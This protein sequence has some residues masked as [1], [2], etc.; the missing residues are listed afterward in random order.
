MRKKYRVEFERTRC[1]GCECIY[2]NTTGYC[3]IRQKGVFPAFHSQS[4]MASVLWT[5]TT[6]WLNKKMDNNGF[7]W[8]F[9]YLLLY[10]I[11]TCVDK[12]LTTGT[13]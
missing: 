2:R 10:Y 11:F 3:G 12:P 8:H 5:A 7:G 13:E 6:A 1:D 9:I 4:L